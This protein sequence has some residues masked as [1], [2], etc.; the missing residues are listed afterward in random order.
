V[1]DKVSRDIML[2][3]IIGKRLQQN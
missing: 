2:I 1:F 3:F